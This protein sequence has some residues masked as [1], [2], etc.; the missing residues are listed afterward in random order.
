MLGIIK[1]RLRNLAG[2][3]YALAFVY[4]VWK[5]EQRVAEAILGAKIETNEVTDNKIVFTISVHNGSPRRKLAT[6]KYCILPDLKPNLAHSLRDC[7][8]GITTQGPFAILPND[9]WP[10]MIRVDDPVRIPLVR[11]RQLYFYFC[12]TI[13]YSDAGEEKIIPLCAV[14]DEA[15]G[16]MGT[17]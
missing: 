13:S 3:V 16:R 17:V 12:G 8:E 15:F 4:Q 10:A 2:S 14:Y 11:T 7:V 1:E 9:S 5:Q 6:L